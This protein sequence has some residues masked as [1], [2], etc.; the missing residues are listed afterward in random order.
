MT[1]RV[2]PTY[3]GP[4]TLR[5]MG[6]G[7]LALVVAAGSSSGAVLVASSASVAA[8][9][10]VVDNAA[11]YT[12]NDVLF[13]V[14][15]IPNALLVASSTAALASMIVIDKDDNTAADLEIHFFTKSTVS[16]GARNAVSTGISDADA[17]FYLGSV[18]V[19]AADWQDKGGVK[20]AHVVPRDTTTGAA[21]P[22]PLTSEDATLPTSVFAIGVTQGTPTQTTGGIV[23]RPF[24]VR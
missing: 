22:L 18:I 12:A 20:W 3:F 17:A 15:E 1:D 14:T 2:V 23:L 7:T 10:P 13:S 6:D 19:K 9:T 16:M 24:I 11:I 4:M 21:K 5:D 8:V